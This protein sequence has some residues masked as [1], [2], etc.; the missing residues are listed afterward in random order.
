[1]PYD[2]PEPL[3]HVR[4]HRARWPLPGDPETAADREQ[5]HQ[6]EAPGERGH[7]ERDGHR[8]RE[9]PATQRRADELV[10]GQL[11]REDPAVGPGQHR[12]ADDLRQDR[13][14]GGV[15]QHLGDA[16]D[17]RDDVQ[18]PD[19]GHQPHDQRGAG[20]EHES[21]DRVRAQHQPAP[22]VAVDE[23]AGRQR[24]QQPGQRRSGGEPT[25]QERVPGRRDRRQRQ[26]RLEHPVGEVGQAGGRPQPP[27]PAAERG[28][29]RVHGI[30]LTQRFVN[31]KSIVVV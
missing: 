24:E 28:R 19:G 16:G 10:G 6:A 17:H 18:Q 8:H 9:Q 22:V 25:D 7:P 21:T 5:H 29:G 31:C 4:A 15:V 14:R 13:L 12:A 30:T 27:E 26:H 11:H 20:R 1:M 23:R 2:E 3:H